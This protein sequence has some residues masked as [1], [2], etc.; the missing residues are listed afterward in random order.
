MTDSRTLAP[1][2]RFAEAFEKESA[3]TL[4]VLRAYPIDQHSLKPHDR[5][6]SAMGLAW[7]FVVEQTMLRRALK[8]EQMFDE[9]GFGTP[10][11]SWNAIVDMF[12]KGLADTMAVLKDPSN[13]QL[14]GNVMFFTGPKQMGE[15]PLH[16]FVW[17][18]LFDQI[19]HRGQMSVYLRLAGGKVPSIYGPSADEPWR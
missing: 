6:S 15:V 7:T 19:H 17:F 11:D 13:Q 16:E 5:S 9:K 2:P 18:M 4:K 3:T 12:E 14:D 8:N 10:P 1:K